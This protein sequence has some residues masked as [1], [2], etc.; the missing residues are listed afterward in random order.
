MDYRRAERALAKSK[1]SIRRDRSRGNTA[2]CGQWGFLFR[3][4]LIVEMGAN[5]PRAAER[6]LRPSRR[7]GGG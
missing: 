5:A 1:Q 2:L 7:W 4:K 6:V 3:P